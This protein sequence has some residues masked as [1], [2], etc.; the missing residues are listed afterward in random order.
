MARETLGIATDTMIRLNPFNHCDGPWLFITSASR[1]Y[2]SIVY[3]SEGVGESSA[4]VPTSFLQ[5]PI[6]PYPEMNS[7]DPYLDLCHFIR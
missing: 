2:S 3:Y 1:S 7:T 6:N 5:E 4:A